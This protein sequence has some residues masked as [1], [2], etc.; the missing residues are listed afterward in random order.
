ML[1]CRCDPLPTFLLWEYGKAYGRQ[2]LGQTFTLDDDATVLDTCPLKVI[3]P[4]SPEL[5]S[6]H[7]PDYNPKKGCQVYR[8]WTVLRNGFIEVVKNETSCKARMMLI[9]HTLRSDGLA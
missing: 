7:T 9:I 8:P 4:L 6:F 3:D 5:L 1:F 2:T